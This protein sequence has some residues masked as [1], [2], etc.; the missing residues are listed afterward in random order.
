[1]NKKISLLLLTVGLAVAAVAATT[2]YT[3]YGSTTAVQPGNPPRP[4]RQQALTANPIVLTN[5]STSAIGTLTFAGGTNMSV[6]VN[7]TGSNQLGLFVNAVTPFASTSNV[8][9]V[10]EFS[11]DG[12]NWL[13]DAAHVQT[14]IFPLTGTTPV[15]FLT[16]FAAANTVNIDF[17]RIRSIATTATNAFYVTNA[18]FFR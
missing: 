8:T 3:P 16:N 11:P 5:L 18:Y 7:S 2:P 13:T 12:I 9:V 17:A 6:A 15:K 10:V 4:D 14:V 1:M